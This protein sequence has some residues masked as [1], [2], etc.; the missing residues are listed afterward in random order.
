[1]T[2]RWLVG[3]LQ[4]LTRTEE[5]EVQKPSKTHESNTADQEH[6][7]IQGPCNTTKMPGTEM[8]NITVTIICQKSETTTQT[9]F[10]LPITHLRY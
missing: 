3:H 8:L 5:N 2:G 10:T 6:L 1:M 9:T 4:L 7:L